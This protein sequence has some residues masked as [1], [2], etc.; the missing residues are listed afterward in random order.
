[1]NI[2]QNQRKVYYLALALILVAIAL[3]STWSLW[4]KPA[5]S[6]SLAAPTP[7]A[8]AQV[9]P[10]PM[11]TPTAEAATEATAS[12]TQAARKTSTIVYYQDNYGYL[13]PVMCSVPLADGIAKA[14]LSMMVQSPDNDMQ[15]A[16]LGLRTV[17]PE[18]TSIDL[19]ISGGLARI[20]LG[21]EVLDMADAAAESN[22]IDAIV[23]TLTE[24]DTVDRVEFLI[25]GQKR[26]K[27]THGTDVSKTF[28]RGDIN[29]ESMEPT[30]RVTD[31]SPVMLY[32]PADSGA[33]IV[34][35]TRMVE[36][37]SDINTAVL[38]LAKGPTGDEMLESVVP[39]GCGLIDVKV[40]DGVAKLNFTG[41]FVNLVQ[42]SDGGRLALKA[43]VLT[44]TQ[45]EGVKSVEIY[46]DGQ[47]Y[48]AAQGELGVPSFMNIADSIYY[49][50]IQTQSNALFEMD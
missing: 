15:A 39:A 40:E 47:K 16:R 36:G 19:D 17:L 12:P 30:M 3:I 4:L 34:P 37:Q 1:M 42:N 11:A 22:M 46:V 38:E 6:A 35:V 23:Q 49:E 25:G 27:L 10:T 13:V 44:C 45:F 5:D 9:T 24:F 2:S 43:L 8:A 41:E 21:R 32:F 33:V 31:A 7:T 48:D 28:T 29:V 18:N 50:A 26:E 20:D 14:T